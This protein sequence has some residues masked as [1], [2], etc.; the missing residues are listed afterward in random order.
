[1]IFSLKYI[2]TL[3]IFLFIFTNCSAADSF[4]PLQQENEIESIDDVTEPIADNIRNLSNPAD[5]PNFTLLPDGRDLSSIVV[6]GSRLAIS[7][8]TGSTFSDSKMTQY[9]KLKIATQTDINHKVQWSFMD[10]DNHKTIAHSSASGRKIFGASSSKIY[11]AATLLDKQNGEYSNS[12]LQKLSDML[13]VSSNSAWTA[14][15]KDIGDG[16]ANDGRELNYLFTQKMGYL[17]TRGWQGYWGDVHGNELVPDETTETLYDI[18]TNGFDGAETLWKLMYTCRTGSTKGKKYIPKNIYVGG[19]TGT[20]DG[21]TEN[22]A[23]GEQYTVKMRNHVLVF[24]IDGRQYGLVIYA[25]NGSNETVALLAGGLIR[26]YA[27]VKIN[28]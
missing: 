19:K 25:N 9:Q 1:M 24:N 27:G 23:T 12:Q 16:V 10:L 5:D 17:Q 14:L 2:S 20:Y 11:V 26:E 21:P 7:K 4:D 15:Q 28:P 22:P 3:I 8:G 18:Y 13:V 6:R